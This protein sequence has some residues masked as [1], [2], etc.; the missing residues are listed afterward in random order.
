[1][2]DGWEK[3][4]STNLPEVDPIM[5]QDYFTKDQRFFSAEMRAV[6]T[7]RS[8]RSSYGD[9]AVGYVQ[10]KRENGICKVRT[11]IT[12]EHKIR[13]KGYSV[14]IHVDEQNKDVFKC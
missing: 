12:P 9:T 3:A 14:E 5:V 2:E 8:C 6:K 11:K 4:N 10:L 1:M 13:Q 7:D